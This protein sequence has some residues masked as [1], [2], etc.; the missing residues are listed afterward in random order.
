M[1]F[2]EPLQETTKAKNAFKAVFSYFDHKLIK[3]ESLVG[4]YTNGVPE[5]LGAPSRFDARIKQRGPNT[6]GT[7][8]VIHH[9]AL[10]CRTLPAA[11]NGKLAIAIRVV[12]FVKSSLFTAL[13]KDMN[14]D[15]NTVLFHTAVQ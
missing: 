11:M 12:N 2:C 9:K 10:A 5:I 14:D 3:W 6:V 7:H 4:V 15:H 13:C 8:C 1:L